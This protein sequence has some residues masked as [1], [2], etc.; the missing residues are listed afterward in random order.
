MKFRKIALTA[1]GTKGA[2]IHWYEPNDKGLSELNKRYP[3]NPI[4]IGL[5][6]LFKDLRVHALNVNGYIHDGM[7]MNMIAQH[8]LE[9]TINR[10]EL[11]GTTIQLIGH[12]MATSDKEVLLET[13]KIEAEDG[14]E[15]YDELFNIVSAI[16]EECTEYMNGSKK[17]DDIEAAMQWV[18]MKGSVKVKEDGKLKSLTIEDI[19]EFSPEKLKDWAAKLLENNFGSV[20]LHS[21]DLVSEGL[22][23]LEAIKELETE[24]TIVEDMGEIEIGVV[25]ENKP[26]KN[27]KTEAHSPVKEQEEF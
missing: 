8:I 1:Q 23:N 2:E 12:K 24:F 18:A 25:K 7:D 4:H 22:D 9:T 10:L 27:K 13:Y 26:K 19:K 20:V 11:D 21:D 14:Y 16:C 6:K 17:M 3:R 5:Q 15:Q